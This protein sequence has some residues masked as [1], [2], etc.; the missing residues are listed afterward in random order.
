MIS[1]SSQSVKGKAKFHT[2]RDVS[3]S[4]S[5]GFNVDIIRIG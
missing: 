4:F 3:T 5:Q 2:T 1:A